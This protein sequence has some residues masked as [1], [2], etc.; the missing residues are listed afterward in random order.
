MFTYTSSILGNRVCV[1]KLVCSLAALWR[2]TGVTE[3]H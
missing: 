3:V 1:R 2:Q